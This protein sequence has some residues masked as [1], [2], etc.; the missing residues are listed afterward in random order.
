MNITRNRQIFLFLLF[1][2]LKNQ[3]VKGLLWSAKKYTCIQVVDI[4]NLK[5]VDMGINCFDVRMKSSK[6]IYFTTIIIDE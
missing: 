2:I 3:K 6:L 4:F 1:L 5:I